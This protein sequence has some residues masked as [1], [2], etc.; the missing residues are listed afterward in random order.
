MLRMLSLAAAMATPVFRQIDPT[1]QLIR[2]E[3]MTSR[4]G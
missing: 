4:Q 2:P 3:Q 1:P